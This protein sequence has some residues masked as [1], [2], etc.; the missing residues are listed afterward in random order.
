MKTLKLVLSFAFVSSV[1]RAN[2]DASVLKLKIYK[3]AFSTSE[4]CTGLKTVYEKSATEATYQ[5]FLI[6]P[7]IAENA[8]L[9]NGDYKCVVIEFSDILKVT[10]SSATGSC[11]TTEYEQDVCYNFGSGAPTSTLIDGTSATCSAT[12]GTAD[13]VAMY[14]STASTSTTGTTGHNPWAAPTSSSDAN[15]GFNLAASF[16]KS[17][18]TTAKFVVN[19]NG[20][21]DGSGPSCDML[22]PLFSFAKK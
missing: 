5:D 2:V 4:L 19:A 13:R 21:V 9:A 15:N 3:V 18:T 12:K 14:I 20:K 1:C 6:S 7:K 11:G 17:G 16:V 10:P 22:P 8:T